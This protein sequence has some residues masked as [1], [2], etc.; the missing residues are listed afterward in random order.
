MK[1]SIRQRALELGFDD[2]RFTTTA[3]P[4][5]AEQFQN[6]LAGKQ[7]G[8]MTWLER[9]A[10]K[11]IDPQKILSGA[12]SL[13]CLAA[14]YGTRAES[15]ESRARDF[16]QRGDANS[17][18]L[19]SLARRSKAEKARPSTALIARYARFT[20]YHDVLGKRLK[21]LTLFVNETGK[22]S[23]GVSPAHKNELSDAGQRPA[24]RSLWYVDTG[25]LL[26]RDF[27]QRAG[28]GFIGKHTNVISR[29]WGNWIFLA[30]IIT[31]LE[32]E[33]DAPEKNHCGKCERCITACPTNAITAPFQLDARRCISYLTIEL[34]GSIPVELRPA[35]GNRIF[36][37]DDCLAACPWNRFAQQGKMMKGHARQ[38]LAAPDLIEL[39]QLDEAGFKSRFAGTPV[40]RTK[41]RGLL[42]NVCVALGNVGDA[43]ALPH[44]QKAAGDSEPLIAEHA[45]WAMEEILSRK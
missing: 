43:S 15:R 6:W 12:K 35:I 5:S 17:S 22:S 23:A 36:G 34:K 28:L 39:L 16:N 9:G 10:S 11:R 45:R 8:E 37:C 27:A 32:L 14:N 40:L 25:P 19:D 7:H 13:I 24:P 31:T 42:R 38:E 2:C 18:T 41:R 30:E 4:A 21:T 44:L 26:E 29:Q 3:A 1:E 20:D 33:P